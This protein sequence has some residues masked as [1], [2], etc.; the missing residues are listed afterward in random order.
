MTA[1]AAYRQ[2]ARLRVGDLVTGQSYVEPQ[3]GTRE[4]PRLITG[5]V[6]QIGSG[7]TGIDEDLGYVWV[8]LPC[9][10]E[11]KALARGLEKTTTVAPSG[12]GEGHRLQR[13]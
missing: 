12:A 7:W 5:T 10:R 4:Q 2:T 3:D 8:R 9:G 11:A 6:A 13:T 1:T